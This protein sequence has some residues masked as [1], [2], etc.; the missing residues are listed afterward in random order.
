[1]T[2]RLKAHNPLRIV[3]AMK[4]TAFFLGFLLLTAAPSFAQ[5]QQFGVQ[6]GGSKRLF[7]D[8][9]REDQPNL[10]NDN[11]KLSNS[12]K[13][14]WYGVDLEPGTMFKIKVGEID[15]P[16]GVVQDTR[17]NPVVTSPRDGKL[18]H[19]DGI[20]N[21]RFSE[22]FGSTGLFAGVGFYRSTASGQ[23]SD[24]NYGFSGGVNADF[25]ITRRFGFI[26]EATYHWVNYSYR[27][28]FV[29][30]TGGLRL[31]F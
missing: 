14:V 26:G 16:M 29:T 4:K 25:P 1:M 7:S 28:R 19:V 22:A 8:K 21:Y 17:I 23:P 6:V 12:V 9:D 13:E 11:F 5:Y 10:P 27:A 18:Q 20:I 2:R 24:T 3:P 30:V 15:G 31:S